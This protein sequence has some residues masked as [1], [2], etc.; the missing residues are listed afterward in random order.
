MRGLVAALLAL[1][2]PC[3]GCG[4]DPE[5]ATGLQPPVAEVPIS[6]PEMRSRIFGPEDR[7]MVA[8]EDDPGGPDERAICNQVCAN[9]VACGLTTSAGCPTLCRTTLPDECGAA[10]AEDLN[11]CLSRR[12]GIPLP[13]FVDPRS[14]ASC[15]TG[16]PQVDP[17]ACLIFSD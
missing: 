14:A 6:N 3:L 4:S 2:C 16:S 15:W 8:L 13:R 12:C 1:V 7:G 9:L 17:L 11:L 10:A 5:A